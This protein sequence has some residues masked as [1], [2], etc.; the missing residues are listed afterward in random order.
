M[1]RS[2]ASTSRSTTGA[3]SSRP[4]TTSGWR[5]PATLDLDQLSEEILLRAVSLSTRG[6]ARS[7]SREDRE[8]ERLRRLRR[9]RARRDPGSRRAT[10]APSSK[11]PARRRR[12]CWRC[13]SNRT[14]PPGPAGGRRQGEPPRRRPVPDERPPHAR[15]VR[16]PGGDR[17]RERSAPPR[18]AGEGAA[19]ARDGARGRDP[20]PDPAQGD[21]AD[22]RASRSPAGTGRRGR[23]AATTTTSFRSR[24]AELGA[25]PRRRLG[26]GRAGG[27]A[28]VDAAL[29]AAAAARPVR[30]RLGAVRAPEPAHPR[31]VGGEQVH[32]PVR[33]PARRRD[34]RRCSTSTPA[35]TLACWCGPTARS[36]NW[37]R[38]ACRSACCPRC[39]SAPSGSTLAPGDLLCLYS[40]GITEAV[41]P[42]DEE[43]GLDRL[44]AL[45]G[46]ASRDPLCEVVSRID[47]EVSAHAAGLPQGDDQTLLLL[48]RS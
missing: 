35:T 22:R 39:R 11:H 34:R 4:S 42:S 33:C 10:L 29:G 24:R 38:A 17:A 20:A 32:H 41:S 5:S 44:A 37:A 36:S 12:T 23:S 9:R 16:Q 27:A 45:L 47:R 48:R 43:F 18:G 2:S 46:D 3:S 31:V 15:A 19:R 7:T 28:G 30:A 26:Q 25:R 13:R 21:A 14:A 8:L 6:A 40:D 1:A